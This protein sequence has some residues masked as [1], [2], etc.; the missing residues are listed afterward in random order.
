[1]TQIN[2]SFQNEFRQ[3]VLIHDACS[4]SILI[5]ASDIDLL[6]SGY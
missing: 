6:T 3:S 4:C 5:A 2:E 1:M